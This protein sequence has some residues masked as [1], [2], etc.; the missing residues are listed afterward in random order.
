MHRIPTSNQSRHM[1]LHQQLAGNQNRRMAN[2]ARFLDS[3]DAREEAAEMM[4][5]TLV[6]DGKEV[7]YVWPKG[8]KYREGTRLELIAF[9][10]RRNYA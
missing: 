6:R 9:L 4:V 3:I 7:R 1:N 10:V 2:E 5:G 8:G